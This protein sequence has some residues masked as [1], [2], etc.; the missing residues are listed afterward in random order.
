MQNRLNT[1]MLALQ[2]T[3]HVMKSGE[4]DKAVSEKTFKDYKI[5]Y[6]YIAHGQGQKTPWDKILIVTKRVCFFDHT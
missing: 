2:Q 5:L 4:M 6:M 3:A 1:L